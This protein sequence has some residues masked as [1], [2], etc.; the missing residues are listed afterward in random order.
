LIFDLVIGRIELS[1]S[2]SVKRKA[3]MLELKL[4]TGGWG[5]GKY[6]MQDRDPFGDSV[7]DV[8]LR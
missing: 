4:K 3:L 7:R 8:R 6:C 2:I 5:V 1:S